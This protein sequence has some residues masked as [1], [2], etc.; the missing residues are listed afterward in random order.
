MR[1][2]W[3]QWWD[4]HRWA[5]DAALAVAVA[6]VA[7]VVGPRGAVGSSGDLL[8]AGSGVPLLFRRTAPRAAL[9][10][11]VLYL[12]GFLGY[13]QDPAVP[14]V[15]APILVHST[16]LYADRLWGWGAVAAGLLGALI[17]PY[18]WGFVGR[19]PRL[20]VIV[21]GF[22]AVSVIA[23]Y[24][25]AERRRDRQALQ[26]SRERSAVEQAE[27]RA[28]EQEQRSQVQL[29]Q[30]RARIARELHDIVAHSLSVVIVQ[31]DGAAAAVAA[32]P[33]LA[34]PVL[35]T[36]GDTSREALAEMRTL[37]GVL[38][39]DENRSA[40]EYDPAQGIDDLPALV[41]QVRGAGVDVELQSAGTPQPVSPGLGLTVYR[42]VQEGLT[43][44][45]KHAGPRARTRVEILWHEDHLAVGV[46][47]DGRGAAAGPSDGG[48]GLLGM[49]E[50]VAA[51]RG[52]VTA[53]PAAGGG[54]AVRA[55]FPLVA[56]VR[57]VP[58][59]I[60]GRTG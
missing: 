26:V 34:V 40:A 53:G 12:L 38:R 6:I 58:T 30:E 42:L 54:F 2:T 23:A 3:Y 45:L 48:H 59:R 39:G 19:D 49:R 16:A 15:L 21:A 17:G 9:L 18:R 25:I 55:T 31:A 20:Y 51:Q 33:E 44:V 13:F 22:C 8:L 11:G 10:L 56:Q 7:V 27:L 41:E 43:N 5:G 37:V 1:S 50:R 14:V 60:P 57:A 47:D 35:R 4:D 52:I 46:I 28:A 36:I 29:A 24:A 32:K